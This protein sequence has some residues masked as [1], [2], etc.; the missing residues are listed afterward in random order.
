MTKREIVNMKHYPPENEAHLDEPGDQPGQGG[1]DSGGQSG[2]TQ[3]LS[4]ATN[5]SE[6]TVEELADA[7]RITRRESRRASRMPPTIPRSLCPAIT[8]RSGEGTPRPGGDRRSSRHG[9]SSAV[10]HAGA[11]ITTHLAVQADRVALVARWSAG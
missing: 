11:E 10:H 4:Q 2:D 8:G 7:G 1:A 5:A 3:G 9:S 6:E